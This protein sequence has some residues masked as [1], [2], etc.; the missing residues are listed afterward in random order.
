[1]SILDDANAASQLRHDLREAQANGRA[2][3]KELDAA[4]AVIATLTVRLAAEKR[5][6][7]LF[8]QCAQRDGQRRAER[9][10][11]VIKDGDGA[12]LGEVLPKRHGDAAEGG[13]A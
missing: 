2:I 8:R 7:D 6:A 13:A 4:L 3:S 10:R 1:M 11:V 12:P 9:F 5:L